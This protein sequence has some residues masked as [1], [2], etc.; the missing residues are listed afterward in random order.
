MHCSQ[1][2]I[3][4]AVSLL[5]VFVVIT[6]SGAELRGNCGELAYVRAAVS[7]WDRVSNGER[8]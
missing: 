4:C 6:L 2:V 8:S 7:V 5:K 1:T 3:M